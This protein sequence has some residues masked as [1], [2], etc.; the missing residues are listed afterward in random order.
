MKP[1][2]DREYD[3]L[4]QRWQANAD[5]DPWARLLLVCLTT[6]ARTAELLR[7]REQDWNS[8]NR[9]LHVHTVK[10]GRPRTLTLGPAAAAALDAQVSW[11]TSIMPH[12]TLGDG[13][14]F[15]DGLPVEDRRQVRDRLR[16]ECATVDASPHSPHDLRCTFA[17]RLLAAGWSPSLIMAAMG[18]RSPASLTVYLAT[19]VPPLP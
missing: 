10:G 13:L 4:L 3:L 17:L 12:G 19:A 1:L 11:L 14:I 15:G 6:G 5:A 8:T 16:L 18:H 7:L 9:R 2:N